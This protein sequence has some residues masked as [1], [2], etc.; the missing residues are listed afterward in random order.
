LRGLEATYTELDS[1]MSE[2][3]ENRSKSWA[4][5]RLDLQLRDLLE[6]SL[7]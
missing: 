5:N 4:R 1:I 3:S 7:G 6:T 2:K